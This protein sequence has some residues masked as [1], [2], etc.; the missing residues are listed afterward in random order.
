MI[1]MVCNLVRKDFLLIR[2]YVYIMIAV[3]FFAPVMMTKSMNQETIP[4]E[5]YGSILFF[6]VLFVAVLFLSN[7]V[8]I[9][10]ETYKKGCAYLCCTPYG[11][12]TIVFSRYVFSYLIFVGYCLIYALA[13]FVF[14]KELI[15]ESWELLLISLGLVSVFRCVLIPLE[16]KFGYEKAKYVIMVLIVGTPFLMGLVMKEFDLTKLDLSLLF[17]QKSAVVASGIGLIVVINI[18]SIIISCI[19]F[20]RKEF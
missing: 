7:S 11:R 14:P 19:I 12:R 9:M 18:V 8:S 4:L 3:S 13:S 10:D 5:L 6:L 17:D 16:L 2:K 15:K 1:K 20:D